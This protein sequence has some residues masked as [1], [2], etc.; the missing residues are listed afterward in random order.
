ME[1]KANQVKATSCPVPLVPL[2]TSGARAAIVVVVAA[3]VVVV[4]RLVLRA[5][6]AAL[7]VLLITAAAAAGLA[8]MAA[9]AYFV[10]RVHRI[11]SRALQA[12]PVSLALAARKPAP[13]IPASQQLAI[14]APRQSADEAPGLDELD[15]AASAGPAAVA[16]GP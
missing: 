15:E 2:S 10:I 13:A 11:Q 12:L 3:V 7:E 6:E 5:A 16:P 4:A 8:A 9:V 14:E 1:G